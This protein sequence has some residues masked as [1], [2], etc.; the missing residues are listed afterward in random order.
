[1]ITVTLKRPHDDPTSFYVF[2]ADPE[3]N[4]VRRH[5]GYVAR[6]YSPTAEAARKRLLDDDPLW[7]GCK[8]NCRVKIKRWIV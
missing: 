1:M 7:V 4:W 8:V 2:T 3:L 6:V 5:G